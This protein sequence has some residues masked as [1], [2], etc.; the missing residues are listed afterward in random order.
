MV[1]K[2]S[3]AKGQA[4]A[5]ALDYA[6][7]SGFWQAQVPLAAGEHTSTGRTASLGLPSGVSQGLSWSELVRKYNKHNPNARDE[8]ALSEQT[9]YRLLRLGAQRKGFHYDHAH[10]RDFGLASFPADE[11]D[12]ASR[13]K[14]TASIS[15]PPPIP[16]SEM[17][18]WQWAM[19]LLESRA[20]GDSQNAAY[21][22][23]LGYYAVHDFDKAVQALQPLADELAQGETNS[24]FSGAQGHDID[25]KF[26]AIFV[27]ALSQEQQDEP[28]DALATYRHAVQLYR[29]LHST[30]PESDEL[31]VYGEQALYRAALLSNLISGSD[32]I[33]DYHRAY[34]A[35]VPTWPASYCTSKRSVIYRSYLRALINTAPTSETSTEDAH[36]WRTEAARVVKG[37]EDVLRT[38]TSFPKAGALN[39]P[40]VDLTDRVAELWRA[41]GSDPT[42]APEL[43]ELMY[44]C[45]THTFQSQRLLRYLIPL[46]IATREYPDA[47]KALDLYVQLFEKAKETNMAEV[48]QELVESQQQ[49]NR[50]G[51]QRNGDAEDD[52]Q[53]GSE[54]SQAED[55]QAEPK[56]PAG[57][58]ET[59]FDTDEQFIDTVLLGMRLLC[60]YLEDPD[61]ALAH[62]RIALKTLADSD[63]LTDRQ[64]IEARLQRMIGIA[65]AAKARHDR[66]PDTRPKLQAE[67]LDHLEKSVGLGEQS[68][69]TH[70][71]LAYLHLELRHVSDAD[72]HARAALKLDPTQ[73]VAWHVL[74]L[75][76]TAQK[77]LASAL[78]LADTA[79]DEST[80]ALGPAHSNANSDGF[81][82]PEEP[83]DGLHHPVNG[84]NSDGHLAAPLTNGMSPNAQVHRQQLDEL[85]YE[86]TPTEAAVI[87]LQLRMTR[88]VILEALKGPEVALQDQQAIFRHFAELSQSVASPEHSV[89]P[90]RRGS[91][92]RSNGHADE[93]NELHAS[94]Q[95][96]LPPPVS[97]RVP[98]RSASIKSE[99]SSRQIREP[100]PQASNGQPSTA[101]SIASPVSSAS[102]RSPELT[103]VL[104]K[105]WLM[106][107]ATFR[108][109]QKPDESR[110][111]IQEAETTDP[112]D[113][114]VWVQLALYHLATA[115]ENLATTALSKAL[116][117]SLD[118]IPA[119]IHMSTLFIDAGSFELAEGLLNILTQTNGWD[120]PEAWL[121]LA[122]V[123]EATRRPQK[124]QDCLIYGVQ[125]EETRPLRPLA[126]AVPALL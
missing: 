39:K 37:Y 44:R 82:T 21:I 119:V 84:G 65:T 96:Q 70:Y 46:H 71:H 101:D 88:N 10:E 36:S 40:V 55:G 17:D 54:A 18:G 29:H 60:K 120:V 22:S 126:L 24:L 99:Y 33:I 5:K 103:S 19:H 7:R 38:S 3:T 13:G 108:R 26:M 80:Q 62:S 105:L 100:T 47:R 91:L 41:A 93:S 109:W 66:D 116:S 51:S 114:D 92:D 111:A 50:G 27:L 32:T 56:A 20:S 43:I 9:I 69:D 25:L 34:I 87:A 28:Q 48:A 83:A 107:A 15:I 78:H 73:L 68:F 113:P 74:I 49:G 104:V 85:D 76:A 4:Y 121:L 72:R 30:S 122:K 11:Q 94:Q 110:G 81:R 77:D 115:N 98:K 6:R 63:A 12:D 58:G 61:A 106:S 67:A 59:D 2:S 31:Q 53:E 95:G 90:A 79:L 118:H 57:H 86:V 89:A 112:D 102:E 23:A 123:N 125:L 45:T 16:E 97:S 64:R 1:G 52:D 14:T 124:A 75:I 35:A 117:F 8:T 42:D